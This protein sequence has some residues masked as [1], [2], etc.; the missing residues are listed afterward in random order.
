MPDSNGRP[1]LRELRK[2]G[3]KQGIV[4]TNNARQRKAFLEATVQMPSTTDF[5]EG[6]SCVQVQEVGSHG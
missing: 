1:Y 2:E 4:T 5:V 6:V 3:E